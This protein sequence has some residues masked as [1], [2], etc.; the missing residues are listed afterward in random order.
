MRC[1]GGPPWDKD[2]QNYS[3]DLDVLKKIL[4]YLDNMFDD[5]L[6][7]GLPN[8]KKELDR[9]EHKLNYILC[10]K[11]KYGLYALK[12]DVIDCV[13]GIKEMLA[14]IEKIDHI[15]INSALKLKDI[16]K[17]VRN[18][19]K[20][21]CDPKF[22]L[23][24][25]K[26]EVHGIEK[27]LDDP[28]FGLQEI[29]S[30]VSAI[31]DIVKDL[32]FSGDL[33]KDIKSEVSNIA[34]FSDT[35][36]LSE[37]KAEVSAIESAVFSETFGLSEIKAEVSQLL[38]FRGASTSLTTGPFFKDNN[39]Q[40]LILKALNDTSIPQ[41]VTFFVYDI[42][43]CPKS[44]LA[45]VPFLN[46]TECCAASTEVNIGSDDRELEVRAQLSTTFGIFLYAATRSGQGQV[47]Q[48]FKAGEWLP[49][50]TF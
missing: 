48:V 31:L 49:A 10:K 45:A 22:G 19:E 3:K 27:K 15:T 13:K 7:P 9:I 25:I 40:S 41:S 14:R 44:L 50:S 20:A 47:Q 6:K 39:E 37:I 12:H 18:I 1:D 26:C 35:F 29:K 24:E 17:E 21:V 33:L 42:D 36:G 11:S 16:K 23:K 2:S 46:I 34:V 30:N 38:A 8:F 32:D 28:D 5:K 4:H 43:E